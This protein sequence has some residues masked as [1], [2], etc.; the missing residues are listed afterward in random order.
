MRFLYKPFGLAAGI[1]GA[2][3]GQRTFVSI[4]RQ[5]DSAE[6]PDATAGDAPLAKVVAAAALEAATIAAIGA[7]VDHASA[8]AFHRVVG[9]WPGKTQAEK[10]AEAEE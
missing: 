6:P 10:T 3:V 1:I 8:S 9:A 5:L 7:L 4:W 2:K